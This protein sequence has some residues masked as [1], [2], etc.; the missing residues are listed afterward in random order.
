MKNKF[1]LYD[2]LN[3]LGA[4]S[5]EDYKGKTTKQAWKSINSMYD[6][7]W[8]FIKLALYGNERSKLYY[9]RAQFGAVAAAFEIINDIPKFDFVHLN[10][11][12]DI[13]N[14]AAEGK[15]VSATSF[16]NELIFW[17]CDSIK[18]LSCV[19]NL[20]EDDNSREAILY[21][22]KICDNIRRVIEPPTEKELLDCVSQYLG[23][24]YE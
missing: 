9:K 11:C 16:R 15:K 12:I 4:C 10:K 20:F 18:C 7:D 5:A 2:V 8:F 24:K 23:E 14:R 17:Q 22:K 13:L 3:K 19:E 21:Q 1:D 6:F